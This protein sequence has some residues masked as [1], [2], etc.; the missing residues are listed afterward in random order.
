MKH[1]LKD[2]H[3]SESCIPICCDNKTYICLSK[4][5]IL[6]SR[7][8]QIQIKRHFIRDY[9]E[10]GILDIKFANTDYQWANILTKPLTEDKF[11]YIK[12][13]LNMHFIKD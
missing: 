5:R 11:I 6:H 13:N 12:K 8:K 10:K 9:V 4:N 1:Q 7:A 3:I 2:Y